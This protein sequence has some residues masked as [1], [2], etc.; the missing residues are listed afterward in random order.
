MSDRAAALQ[1]IGIVYVVALLAAIVGAYLTAAAGYDSPI[2][3][4]AV[5]DLVGTL[6][7]FGFSVKY[8][9]S[10]VYDAYWSVAPIVLVSYLAWLG[11][12]QSAAIVRVVLVVALVWLWGVRLTHNWARGWTGFEHEDWRYRDMRAQTN[13]LYWLVSL[14]GIHLFP[15]VI[16]FL[17]CL[18]LFVITLE[19]GRPL[20][21]IDGVAALVTGAAVYL[22][23]LADN[24]LR[25]YTL[26]RK[27]PGETMTEGIWAWSRHPNYL[28]ETCFWWG[29]WLFGVAAVGVDRWWMISGAVAVTVLFNFISI[30]LIERRMVARRAD[31]ADVQARVSR[32]LLWPPRRR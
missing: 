7:V 18:P 25:D 3:Q 31:Y 30:P 29:L 32:L 5:A 12:S 19:P 22:E 2:V 1:K 24:Q 17:G 26:H 28:G 23:L 16:V 27:R 20:G 11:A 13:K 14:L 8:D 15:T 6:V 10:S 4:L 21:W 9:N